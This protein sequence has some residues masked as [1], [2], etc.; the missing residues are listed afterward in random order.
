VSDLKL[1]GMVIEKQQ[2]PKTKDEVV[3]EWEEIT[4]CCKLTYALPNKIA[5][6]VGYLGYERLPR[7][8]EMNHEMEWNYSEVR[9]TVYCLLNFTDFFEF[10]HFTV[11]LSILL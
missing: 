4:L 11:S 10:V 9:L 5:S 6:Y 2:S 8:I 1:D 3:G 7:L